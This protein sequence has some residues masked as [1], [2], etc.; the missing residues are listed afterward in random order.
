[1]YRAAKYPEDITGIY[2]LQKKNLPGAL[3]EEERISEGFVTVD[4][5]LDLL[6][7]MNERS[8]HVVAV[9]NEEV[10][11]YAL[12]MLKDFRHDIPILIPMFDEIDTLVY[13]GQP[14]VS[15]PYF[16]MGQ[17]C[18]DAPSRGKGIFRGLYNELARRESK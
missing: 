1:M 6:Q 8:S 17:I 9:H 18:I 2:Q 11:G 4:H 5:E 16:I 10:I 13:R 14:L 15:A 12:T 3:S 7:R